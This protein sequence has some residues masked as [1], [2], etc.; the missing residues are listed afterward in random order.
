M[1]IVILDGYAANPDGLSWEE[2]RALG[3]VVIHPRTQ[4]EEVVGRI[5][6]AEVVLTNKVVID[7]DV[8]DRCP[9]LCYIGV[10][11][12]GYNVVD[13]QRAE[14]RGIVVTNIP[15]YST[16]SVAQMVFAHLLTIAN[17]VERHTRAVGDGKWQNCPD[18]CFW[19]TP[20]IEL[21]GLTLGIVG[22]GNTGAAT[23]RVAQAFGMKVMA[24]SS[25]SVEQL[26]QMG[27]EKAESLAALFQTA[28][29]LSLHCPL[30]PDTRHI[31]SATTLS[32]M[33]PSAIVINTGRGPLVDEAALA[34]ALRSNRIYAA[35]IDVL[36]NEPPC[37]GSPLIGLPNCFV[38]P[39][40]AW[41]TR[42]AR[43]RL[44]QVATD[45]VR[46]FLQGQKL[47]RIT[48]RE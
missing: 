1:K 39:H 42:A 45:N 14:Q 11:A 9:A 36:E 37:Q 38:T 15:A 35:G 23:A 43:Q 41:A 46:A 30:T 7:A 26:G 16:Q 18:F 21:A 12:T 27:I 2:L 22:V 25:K 17:R 48:C 6:D 19:E 34:D 29:V 5:G 10:L 4:P 32:L 3:E 40:I 20:Q 24:L 44:L 31:V 8:M 28:D 47:N 13:I 33:K